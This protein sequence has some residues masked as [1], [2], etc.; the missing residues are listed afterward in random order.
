MFG[1]FHF[2]RPLWLVLLPISALIWWR[3]QTVEDPLQGWRQLIDAKLL[4]AICIDAG[5][6][7]RWRLPG[8]LA[9]WLLLVIAL[10][11][12]T[13]SLVPSPFNDDPLPAM[14]IFNASSTMETED[15]QPTRI[16]RAKLKVFDLVGELK[17]QPVGL[18]AYSGTAHLVLP[19]TKDTDIVGQMA[20]ELSPDIMPQDGN[21]FSDAVQIAARSMSSRNGTLVVVS[22]TAPSTDDTDVPKGMKVIWL[23]VT[24][25]AANELARIQSF[26]R[27]VGGTCLSI[28]PDQSDIV[29]ISREVR[30][31][32]APTDKEGDVRWSEPGWWLLPLVAV[33]AL[34]GFR[35]E[36]TVGEHPNE[37]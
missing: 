22:D 20:N 31:S 21:E 16:E 28:A 9:V 34:I 24:G 5:G 33:F 8:L 17:G 30:R 13:W 36:S 12:P 1:E 10:A 15:L 25:N 7:K 27:D 18:V 3:L 2:L 14:I 6:K 35:R 11:G 37:V 23:A 32:Q 4:D 19:P 29:A 26:C